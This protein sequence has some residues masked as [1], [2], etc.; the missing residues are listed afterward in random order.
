MV[1]KMRKS[2]VITIL[3]VAA[4]MCCCLSGCQPLPPVRS[5]EKDGKVC[6]VTR[7]LFRGKWWNHFERGVSFSDCHL[8]DEAEADFR[9]AL[10]KK[11]TDQ[12][13]VRTFGRHLTDYFPNRELGVVLFHQGRYPEAI[14]KLETS[15]STE[16]SA[17]SEYYLDRA[18]KQWIGQEE[19][20]AEPPEILIESPEHTSFSNS[21]AI[22]VRGMAKDDTYVDEIRING[23]PVRKEIRTHGMP[24]LIDRSAPQ[25]F[26][27][28]E[29]PIQIG[30][31]RIFVEVSDLSDKTVT[32]EIKVLCDRSGP[33]L[34]IDELIAVNHSD[35]SY[36]IRGYAHDDS[37]IKEI[38]VNGENILEG[39]VP[40]TPINNPIVL[41]GDQKK[42]IV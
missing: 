39:P 17:K 16:T 29:I 14:Q 10:Q 25:V 41:S 12:R 24:V 36:M 11:A 5:V 15:L 22:T 19:L 27:S 38:L 26:F 42:A 6:G 20:D 13:G 34:N 28:A 9:Q 1:R 31:N 7:G 18:R 37:G 4:L 3:F 33:A 30:E 40:E 21:F 35:G 23:D 32:R 2:F 8:W